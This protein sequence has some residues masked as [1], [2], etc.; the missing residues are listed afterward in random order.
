MLQ[1][2]G[3]DMKETESLTVQNQKMEKQ[4][5]GEIKMPLV[6]LMLKMIHIIG[7]LLVKLS[8]PIKL[9]QKRNIAINCVYC[10]LFWQSN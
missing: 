4:Y 10:D 1:E 3:L 6:N 2:Q 9:K 5:I 7:L 8:S